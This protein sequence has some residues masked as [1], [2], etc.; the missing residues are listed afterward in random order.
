M[1]NARH[2]ASQM[3]RRKPPSG[4][5][6]M[7]FAEAAGFADSGRQRLEPAPARPP[8]FGADQIV[9]A[10]AGGT[11]LVA[12][13]AVL[14]IYVGLIASGHWYIDEYTILANY[15]ESKLA[16]LADHIIT[17]SPRPVSELLL[18]LYSRLVAMTGRPL[19]RW[20]LGALWLMFLLSPVV[21]V[22]WRK[23][24]LTWRLAAGLSL[25]IMLIVS[26]H[27]G[28]VFFWPA[29]AAAY[30]PSLAALTLALFLLADGR[31]S[32]RRGN[33]CLTAALVAAAWSCETGAIFGACYATLCLL[34]IAINRRKPSRGESFL[35]VSV[36]LLLA[37]L[38]VLGL[39]TLHRAS[40][41]GEMPDGSVLLIHHPIAS[42]LAALRAMPL[43]LAGESGETVWSAGT[44]SDLG[45]GILI[46]IAFAVGF[47]SCWTL[48]GA[49][50]S[51]DRRLVLFF[52]A[53][54][55]TAWLA[56]AASEYQ[57]GQPCCARHASFRNAI[58]LLG[59]AAI[60][61]T[62]SR[63][64][65]PARRAPQS[66]A[67]SMLVLAALFASFGPQLP[68]I[69]QDYAA[70]PTMRSI[71]TSNWTSGRS[72][73]PAMVFQQYPQ[74]TIQVSYIVPAGTYRLEDVDTP[75]YARAIMVFFHKQLLTILPP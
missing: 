28:Q 22:Q 8:R 14:A 34:D 52:L 67:A 74:Q 65:L 60:A 10:T 49:T 45:H 29:G 39:M 50:R 46:K 30:L 66:W 24:G 4:G 23:Q 62:L 43:D 56:L 61:T 9:A 16:V 71:T 72:A 70:R 19:I 53:G 57:L 69:V 26:R 17:W 3:A 63:E 11:V 75:W 32:S 59:L 2:V 42:L 5:F 47:G 13:L 6:G 64:F 35:A 37:S 36:V 25:L 48:S 41:V 18:F 54:I 27:P 7:L 31:A 58:F 51:P 73:G 15:R 20:M 33:L 1:L 68:G 38:L 21:T 12:A 55:A 40:G 44:W